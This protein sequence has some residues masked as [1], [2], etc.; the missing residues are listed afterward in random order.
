MGLGIFSKFWEKNYRGRKV[1]E[2]RETWRS[3][4]IFFD[5]SRKNFE[6]IH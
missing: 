5:H 4:K 2:L 6:K 1:L 3:A